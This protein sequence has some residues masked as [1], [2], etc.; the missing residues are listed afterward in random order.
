MYLLLLSVVIRGP[1][2]SMATTSNGFLAMGA[3]LILKETCIDSLENLQ[4]S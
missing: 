1:T 2:K 4:A 3:D